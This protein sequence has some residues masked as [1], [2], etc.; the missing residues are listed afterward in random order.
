MLDQYKG[1]MVFVEQRDNH[2]Q[3]V[4]LELL[5]EATRLADKLDTFVSAVVVGKDV[6]P[7]A[8][9]LASYGADKVLIAEDDRLEKYL[10]EPYVHAVTQAVEQTKPEI[11]L[12]GA[13]SIG[14]DLAPRVSARVHTGLT[15]DCTGLDIEDETKLLLMTRPAFGGNIMATIICQGHRPQMSTVRPGVMRKI[16]ADKSR[17]AEIIEVELE[18]RDEAF[19]V[20]IL[21]ESV[22]T[23]KMVKI[24][25]AH[26]LVSAGRGIGGTQNL[27]LLESLAKVVGGT[28]SGSRATIDAGWL[29]K[30]RQVGQTGKTVRPD[31]YFALGISGAIQHLAG[32]EESEFIVAINRNPEAPMFQTADLGIVGDLNA[33]IPELVKLL[34]EEKAKNVAK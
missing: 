17:Q 8:D 6:R 30:E 24:E 32:M 19:A 28:I 11:V 2:I 33:V 31:V 15:A 16:E 20:E 13:T 34:E 23:K 3:N 18:L 21:E 25:D 7:L 10:T 1:V 5:G 12:F 27:P 14:R 29:P 4:S 22:E 26:I 9:R